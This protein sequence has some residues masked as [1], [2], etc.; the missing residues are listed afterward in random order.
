M[1]W[2]CR[3]ASKAF[4]CA[5][6]AGAGACWFARQADFAHFL[7]S[8]SGRSPSFASAPG[9]APSS[10]R[11]AHGRVSFQTR[12]AAAAAAMAP[13]MLQRTAETRI[14]RGTQ[15]PPGSA[16]LVAEGQTHTPSSVGAS[17]GRVR[18]VRGL[19]GMFPFAAC[20]SDMRMPVRPY[21]CARFRVSSAIGLGRYWKMQL[22]WGRAEWIHQQPCL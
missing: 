6:R 15:A 19:G 9:S 17:P 10:R 3:A 16:A 21:V 20:N 7:R 5:A 2:T 1:E 14:V 18:M 22:R 4:V 13:R 8:S 11:D 12:T